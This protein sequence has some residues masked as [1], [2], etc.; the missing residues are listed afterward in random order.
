MNT[1]FEQSVRVRQ[2]PSH[3]FHPN[4]SLLAQK[5]HCYIAFPKEK[6][7]SETR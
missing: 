1:K 6:N 2:L 4:V 5:Q 7:V 3:A